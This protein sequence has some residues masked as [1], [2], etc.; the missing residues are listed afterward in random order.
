M[1]MSFR[2]FSRKL[3]RATGDESGTAAIEFALVSPLLLVTLIGG[4]EVT[5]AVIAARKAAV[6]TRTMADLTAQIRGTTE[7]T[8]AMIDEVYAA[9]SVV[10]APYPAGSLRVAVSRVDV[11][12]VNNVLTARTT[13]STTRNGGTPRPCAVLNR[14]SN[15]ANP[16]PGS[17]PEGMYHPS[18][19]IVVDVVYTYSAPLT[20][21][22][23]P[24]SFG[25][26]GWTNTG[27]GIE[28]RKTAYMQTRI[29]GNPTMTGPGACPP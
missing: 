29:D 13:W 28:I 11:T 10:M 16:E 27:N 5:Q 6:A 24:A 7:V 1:L 23:A 15:T 17:F 2:K 25:F 9:G 12:S 3:A 26:S 19:F 21:N 22:F 14:I 4:T 18:R 20:T 8:A